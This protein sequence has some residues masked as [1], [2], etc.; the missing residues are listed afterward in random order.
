MKDSLQPAAVTACRRHSLPPN[1]AYRRTQ[2]TTVKLHV[3]DLSRGMAS[4]FSMQFLG[5]QIDA[6]GTFL[7]LP[8]TA[9]P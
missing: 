5:K 1:T 4:M 6:S 2:M 7:P 3:Y 9:L 8:Q